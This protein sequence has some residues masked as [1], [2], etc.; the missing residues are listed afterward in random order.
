MRRRAAAAANRRGIQYPKLLL[1]WRSAQAQVLAAISALGATILALPEVQVDPR[2]DRAKQAIALLPGLIP[3][4]GS[5]LADLL[6]K[7]ITAGSDLAIAADALAAVR[8]YRSSLAAAVPLARLDAFATTY[9][10]GLGALE[11]LDG[12]LAEI[13][14]TL[15]A[16]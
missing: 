12:A 5:E 9:A 1:R 3:E 7:G 11:A 14:D 13:A 8:S 15:A 6:D 16:A 10:G 2:L 4:L